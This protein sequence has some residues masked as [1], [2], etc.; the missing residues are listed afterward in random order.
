MTFLSFP[1]WRKFFSDCW[2]SCIFVWRYRWHSSPSILPATPFSPLHMQTW[3]FGHLMHSSYLLCLQEDHHIHGLAHI[4][5]N[6]RQIYVFNDFLKMTKNITVVN[7]STFFNIT[8]ILI[9]SIILTG[10][11]HS[12]CWTD[13]WRWLCDTQQSFVVWI[14]VIF[15]TIVLQL[16]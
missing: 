9:N 14:L 16:L 6:N 12:F 8:I 2:S 13:H 5:L 10:I 15:E 4:H 1:S 11:I 7:G 3:Y